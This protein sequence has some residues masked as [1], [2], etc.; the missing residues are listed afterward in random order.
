METT[1]YD[2]AREASQLE[3]SLLEMKNKLQC[4]LEKQ[5]TLQKSSEKEFEEELIGKQMEL[6]E[7]NS[8]IK[9]INKEFNEM[10]E[11]IDKHKAK[12]EYLEN[13]LIETKKES[14]I[15]LKQM[16][17]E[18]DKKLHKMRD[19]LFQL[20]QSLVEKKDS[21]DFQ[22]KNL[23]TELE[24]QKKANELQ[25]QKLQNSF[26]EQ[27][28]ATKIFESCICEKDQALSQ[29]E[30]SITE[31]E[32]I[33][34]QLQREIKI[35]ESKLDD[36]KV[37]TE[38]L[39]SKI[40]F[41]D[42]SFNEL[43]SCLESNKKKIKLLSDSLGEAAFEISSRD[44]EYSQRQQS[45]ESLKKQKNKEILGLQ[46]LL[47]EN[48]KIIKKIAQKAASPN[49]I[50]MKDL[51]KEVSNLQTSVEVHK[52]ESKLRN[53]NDEIEQLHHALL[54]KKERIK[55]LRDELYK[56]R[57]RLDRQDCRDD[58]DNTDKSRTILENFRNELNQCKKEKEE[59]QITIISLRNEIARESNTSE[60]EISTMSKEF[61][62]IFKLEKKEESNKF[63]GKLK[64]VESMMKD[65]DELLEQHRLL[66]LK[67]QKFSSSFT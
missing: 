11:A 19:A 53:K 44:K 3:Q 23:K 67:R 39:E 58:F 34:L 45:F 40:K 64:N 48:E 29:L 42:I 16:Q 36:D 50:A 35:L 31:K 41:Q 33:I 5:D 2:R 32:K 8:K 22:I 4:S 56:M 60:E 65:V 14:D 30:L 59:M 51:Q 17:E 55:Y 15:N 20:N 62:N 27:K 52:L 26:E 25:S 1:L 61:Q 57:L 46:M 21:N 12:V 6:V 28:R 24:E 13:L 49:K 37:I 18:K 47:E 54:E 38:K 63:R 7:T 66:Q 10:S 9:N 43:V